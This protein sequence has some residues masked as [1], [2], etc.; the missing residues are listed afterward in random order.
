MRFRLTSA[1]TTAARQSAAPRCYCGRLP[2]LGLLQVL[3]AISLPGLAAA[4]ALEYAPAPPDN[5]LKGFAPYAGQARDFPHSME[6]GYLPLRAVMRGTDTFDW[7]P[8]EKLL[9]EV[10]SRGC[11]TVF[12]FYLEYPDKPIGVPHYLLDAGLAIRTNHVA[13][14]GKPEQMLTPDYEDT[15]LRAALTRF[16]AALG[17]RYD[18]DPRVACLTAGLLGKW[19]EWQNYPF[20][21]LWASKS[22]QR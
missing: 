15:R 3:L 11:Q 20:A 14:D 8:L 22:V 2:S 12:R 7:Q 13:G 21:R 10:A 5:P 17:E 4:A 18:G 1:G 19:G 6:F 16:I 9:D